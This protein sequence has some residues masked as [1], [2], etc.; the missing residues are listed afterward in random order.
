M[1]VPLTLTA[2]LL[3][4]AHA[5]T[6]GAAHD[7]TQPFTFWNLD[8]LTGRVQRLTTTGPQGTTYTRYA[9]DGQ[10]RTTTTPD[11]RESSDRI[12]KWSSGTYN[13]N[14]LISPT[15]DTTGCLKELPTIYSPS[16]ARTA[17]RFTCDSLGREI[18]ATWQQPGE[19]RH[20]LNMNRATTY[21]S[22]RRVATSV[23]TRTDLTTGES[24]VTL[25]VTTTYAT[26]GLPLTVD[27]DANG[28][29]TLTRYEYTFDPRGNWITRAR[30]DARG[31]AYVTTERLERTVT[32][33]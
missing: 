8:Q 30:L 24:V 2:L 19:Q 29:R 33:Y 21:T 7:P 3:S 23:T 1:R 12:I 20:T 26:S 25:R 11:S 17:I 32:Y 22:D 9:P 4:A 16:N 10:T 31:G 15:Y 14:S 6:P 13:I 18:G 27:T 5:L 28:T